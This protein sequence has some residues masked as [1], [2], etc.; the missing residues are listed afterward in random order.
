MCVYSESVAESSSCAP[1]SSDKSRLHILPLPQHVRLLRFHLHV[2]ARSM[3]HRS[4]DVQDHTTPNSQPPWFVA[5]VHM[6]SKMFLTCGNIDRANYCDNRRP[7]SVEREE[8]HARPRVTINLNI[9]VNTRLCVQHGVC[10]AFACFVGD[11]EE[12]CCSWP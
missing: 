6:F 12:L 1:T 9:K 4:T 7:T 10:R 11:G 2:P 5:V 3:Q 8:V